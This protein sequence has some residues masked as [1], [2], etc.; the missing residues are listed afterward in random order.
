MS[1]DGLGT[2]LVL[3]VVGMGVVFAALTLL[4]VVVLVL[5]RLLPPPVADDPA[6]APVTGDAGITPE[7]LVVLS[8]AAVA[9]TCGAAR[10]TRVTA[11]REDHT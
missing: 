7:L 9:A 11:A 10:V 8:A 1:E 5:K 6:P 2:G 3:M 4:M